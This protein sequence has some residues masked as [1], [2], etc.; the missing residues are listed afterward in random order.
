MLL[1]TTQAADHLNVSPRRVRALIAAG[2]LPAVKIGRDWMIEPDALERFQA[3]PRKVG[4]PKL[5]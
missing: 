4:R 3:K 1:T 5:T 2:R